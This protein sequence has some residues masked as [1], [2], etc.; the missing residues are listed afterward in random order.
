[1][2]TQHILQIET[3]TQVCSV[4]ISTNGR[5]VT[6]RDI[7]EPNVHASRLTLLI[8]EV[9]ED[10]GLLVT[11]LHAIAVSKGPGSYTGL[12]IGVSTA[13]GLCYATDIPLIGVGTL[14]GMVHGFVASLAQ[15]VRPNTGLIPMIDARRM[16]VYS[17][18]Y[19][20]KLELIEPV[21]ARIIDAASFD[22]LEAE[23]LILFGSGAH[24][25]TDTFADHPHIS[26]VAGFSNSASHFSLLAYETLAA[27]SFVDVAYFEPYYL[28][29]F[30]AAKPKEKRP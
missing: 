18:V 22:H 20:P 28:K 16:E 21:D 3:A 19:N 2:P 11:D 1:M 25:F 26:V 23:N 17:A 9:L 24:K 4:A 29:D 14:E 7:D 13:K 6:Y 15:G 30:V 12:R 27:G 5:T 10:A 8:N